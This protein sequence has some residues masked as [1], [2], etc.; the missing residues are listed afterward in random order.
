MVQVRLEFRVC[1]FW[2]FFF[3]VGVPNK[4]VVLFFFGL[5]H[6]LYLWSPVC[7]CVCV[8]CVFVCVCG[9]KKKR[10]PERWGIF[11]L[12]SGPANHSPAFAFA[13][14]N[15]H[16][17]KWR[18]I[19]IPNK[20]PLFKVYMHWLLRVYTIPRISQQFPGAWC[21]ENRSRL[22]AHHH[23][24]AGQMNPSGEGACFC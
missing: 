14:L 24:T 23:Q 7:L 5:F 13:S 9:K 6:R 21:M 18:Y 19:Y 12:C 15:N 22:D 17:E 4:Q 11:S 2:F 10:Y 1:F 3:W 20:Y 16:R 8:C